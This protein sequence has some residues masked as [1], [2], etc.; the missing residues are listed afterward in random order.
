MVVYGTRLYSR[1]GRC[2]RP[3]RMQA[4]RHGH[5][6]GNGDEMPRLGLGTWKSAPG[7]AY[8]AVKAA[9]AAGYRHI[10]CAAIYANEAEIGRALTEVFAA[11]EL[12][13]EQMWIT[14]KLWNDRHAPADVLP[15]LR[16]TLADLQLEYLDLYLVHWPIALKQ[17][18]LAPRSAA[19]LIPLRELPLAQTWA[20]ME[21]AVELGLARHLGVSNFSAAKLQALH[22]GARVKPE[23]NQVELHPY[24]QQPELLASCRALDV[25]VTAY[26]PLGS[27]DRPGGLKAADEPVLLADP[28]IADI[29]KGQGVSPAQ[30]LIAWALQR[31]TSVIPKSIDPGRMQQNLAAAAL[32]LGDEDMRRIAALER[33]RRYLDGKFWIAGGV[34]SLAGLWDE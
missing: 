28:V 33:R 3:R 26:S 30:V 31:G 23:V 18:V 9:I 20:A 1:G 14:S 2:Y 7:D 4:A 6:F 22:A 25:H 21:P 34:Y 12:R 16:K 32:T 10:D 13:R 11:G 8:R 15:A 19:D 5:R 24:L 17:G 27:G 29:A